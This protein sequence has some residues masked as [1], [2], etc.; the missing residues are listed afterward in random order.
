MDLENPM[1][2][3]R[4]RYT[5]DYGTTQPKSYSRC[6]ECREL[7]YEGDEVYEWEHMELFCTEECFVKKMSNNG[8]LV[9]KVLTYGII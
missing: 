6:D 7:L 5:E 3:G 8:I 2:T 4:D 9:K 1:V